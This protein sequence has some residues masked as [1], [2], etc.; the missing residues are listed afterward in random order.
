[1]KRKVTEKTEEIQVKTKAKAIR[2]KIPGFARGK[3]YKILH[4]LCLCGVNEST[5]P[6]IPASK[7][8]APAHSGKK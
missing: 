4:P 7:R 8:T 5:T 3:I 2:A 1:M 6:N